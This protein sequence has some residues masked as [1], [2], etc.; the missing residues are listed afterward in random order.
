VNSSFKLHGDILSYEVGAYAGELII[1]PSLIWATFY[2]GIN[3]DLAFSVSTNESAN[4]FMCGRTASATSIATIGAYQ[5]LFS[6][7]TTDGFLSKFD[8]VG[9]IVWSTYYGGAGNMDWIRSVKADAL[10]N[11]YISGV[12]NSTSGMTTSGSHISTYVSGSPDMA[13][14]AKFNDMGN[15]VWATYFGGNGGNDAYA[16]ELRGTELYIAGVTSSTSGIAS[17]GAYLTSFGGVNDAFLAKF[18]TS[19]SFQWST[20]FGSSGNDFGSG[21]AVDGL[22]NVMISGYTASTTG[23][24]SIGAHQTVYGGGTI[25]GFIAKFNGTGTFQWA[26][27]IGG[28]LQDNANDVA[29]DAANNIYITGYSRSGSGISTIGSHQPILAGSADAFIAKFDA[30]GTIQWSTYFGGSMDDAGG[31]LTIDAAGTIYMCGSTSSISGITTTGAHQTAYGGNGDGVVATFTS[32]GSLIWATYFGGINTDVTN[33]I[34]KDDLSGIVYVVGQTFGTDAIATPGAYR[35]NNSG[36]YDGF[37]AQF[38]NC[39]YP[40]VAPITGSNVICVNG[41]TL[42]SNTTSSGVWNSGNTSI[43]TVGS[44]GIVTGKSTGITVISYTKSNGCSSTTV[45]INVTANP[46]PAIAPV[47]GPMFVCPGNTITLANATAGGTW[48]S[49]NPA[50]ATVGSTGVVTGVSAGHVLI[51]YAVTSGGCT[52]YAKALVTVGNT[53]VTTILGTGVVGYTGDGGPATAAQIRQPRSVA[54]DGVGNVYVPHHLVNHIVRMINTSGIINR[55]AGTGAVGAGADGI[56]ATASN[57]T[58][59][60]NVAVDGAGNLYI[61]EFGNNR[62]RKV[63]RSTGI[64]TTVAGTGTAGFLGDGGACNGR[65]DD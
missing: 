36:H 20:Y 54:V 29:T 33:T 63:D 40:V 13:F 2:G 49:E 55:V 6:G 48:I 7:G 18:D 37:L 38:N 34:C 24:A 15:R 31:G 12:T 65:K 30:L 11:T 42:L 44:T 53:I 61:S 56:S 27:Y 35:T 16:V 10:G 50:V 8:S 23:I 59:P 47:T 3:E 9:N 5:T 25:D 51:S 41:T 62:V 1:D 17:P 57:M 26:T 39:H 14:L 60:Y 58:T 21:I 64:I 45:T 52:G 22:G 19:G 43:A 32:I 28:S 4:A 46:L